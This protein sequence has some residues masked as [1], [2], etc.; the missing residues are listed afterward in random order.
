M[1]KVR[2]LI[3]GGIGAF[4]F[5]AGAHASHPLG[6]RMWLAAES[7]FSRTAIIARPIEVWRIRYTIQPVTAATPR[8]N[9]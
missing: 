8:H 5:V 1:I 7:S 3:V 4:A 9:Q 6:S 2:A